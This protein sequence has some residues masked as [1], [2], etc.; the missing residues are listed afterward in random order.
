MSGETVITLIGN[1]VDEQA[2]L[3]FTPAGAAV[4]KFRMVQTPRKFNR[5]TN[6]WEDDKERSLF[7]T[8]S[9]WRSQAENVAAVLSKGMRVVVQ[10]ELRQRSYEDREGVKR[11][12][13]EVE[14]EEVAVS[15]KFATARVEKAGGSGQG[16]QQ[17]Q[18]ARAVQ[19]QAS[20]EDPWSSTPGQSQGGWGQQSQ[21]FGD[22]PPF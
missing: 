18:Q 3:R 13:Y 14:A 20:A 8:V 4:A 6:A 12:V 22:E 5:D 17:M 1:V 15:L 19:G 7:L 16:R 9:V 11:T 10:G 21:G 2:E